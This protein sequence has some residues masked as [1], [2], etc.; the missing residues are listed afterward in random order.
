MTT[1]A[2]YAESM[3]VNTTT[4]LG[5]VKIPKLAHLKWPEFKPALSELLGR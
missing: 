2:D 4:V 3:L 1:K 5:E